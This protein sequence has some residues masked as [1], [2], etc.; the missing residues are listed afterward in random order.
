MDTSELFSKFDLISKSIDMLRFTVDAL[1][2]KGEENGSI[3]VISSATD[4]ISMS[5]TLLKQHVH[6]ILLEHEKTKD[7]LIALQLKHEEDMF[8]QEAR[9]RGYVKV[10]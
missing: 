2:N 1:K 8:E 4:T 7:A 6:R 5:A 9:L 3:A 10:S